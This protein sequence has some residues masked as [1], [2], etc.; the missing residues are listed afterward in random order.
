MATTLDK[1]TSQEQRSVV[2]F[3]WAKGLNAKDIHKEMFPI[4]SGTCLLRKAAHNWVDKFSQCSKVTDGAKPDHPVEIAT[5]AAVQWVEEL[6]RTDRRITT[7]NVATALWCSDGLAYSIMHDRLKF[8]EVC[9]QWV[10]GELMDQ[11]KI[12]RMDL[13]LQRLLRYADKEDVF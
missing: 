9:T 7:D 6:V 8:Q 5:D 3:L 2:H 12:N 1:C 10:P 11:E 4:Y 13:S